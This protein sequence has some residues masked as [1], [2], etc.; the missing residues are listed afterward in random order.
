VKNVRVEWGATWPVA[1]QEQDGES[2]T[3]LRDTASEASLLL[4]QTGI[5]EHTNEL[6][7]KLLSNTTGCYKHDFFCSQYK[8]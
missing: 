3:G 4:R 2:G 5:M 8:V 7:L 1:R 6:N